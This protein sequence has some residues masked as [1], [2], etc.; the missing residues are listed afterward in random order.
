[1]MYFSKCV[2][3]DVGLPRRGIENERLAPVADQHM[4]ER[5]SLRIGDKSLAH[6]PRRQLLHIVGREAVQE[7][8]GPRRSL[9]SAY[10]PAV[11][12]RRRQFEGRVLRQDFG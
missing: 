6:A 11:R 1:M 12:R 3:S 5:F 4:P 8:R 2:M 9:R 7:L 10:G